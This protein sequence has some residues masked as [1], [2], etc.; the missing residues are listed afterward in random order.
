MYDYAIKN[1]MIVDGTGAE[2]YRAAVYLQ[3]D[4]IAKIT[5]EDLPAKETVDAAGLAVA[6]GFMD[7]HTHS[8]TTP[9]CAPG[10]ETALTQGLTFH[11]GGNC[12]GSLVPNM[13]EEHLNVGVSSAKSRFKKPMETYDAYDFAS[14][15]DEVE[16]NGVAVNFSTLIG[17]GRLRR[18]VMADPK[19]T[20]PTAEELKGMEEL[21]EKQLKQGA[22]GM[23]IGL[24]YVPGT[25]A[26]TEELIALSKVVAKY[27][28]IVAVHMRSESTEVM[29]A[30]DEMCRVAK[31]SGAHVH[32]SHF[33]LMYE[34]QWGR[35]EELLR[36]LDETRAAGANIT[37]DQYP[38]EAS[39]T[40][41][42]SLLPMNMKANHA[43][44][45]EY[46]MDDAKYAQVRDDMEKKINSRG[47]GARIG[48]SRTD[49]VMP[50]AD[51]KTLAEI[52]D[53]LG[54]P[55]VDAF[56]EIMR[57]S[58]CK[59]GL[60]YYAINEQDMLTIAKRQDIAVAS[61][62]YGYD[63]LVE[64][65]IGKPHPRSAGAFTRFLRLAREHQL[66]PLEKAVRKMTGLPASLLGIKDRGVLKEGNFADV[67]IF[68]PETIT[69]N[70][71][72]A[73]PT[74]PATG[75]K[76]VFVNGVKAFVDGKP[77]GSRSGRF[78][79]LQ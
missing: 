79:T 14:Y 58:E 66:M 63:N 57:R 8:D 2:P 61:D 55:V 23:S 74:K 44:A 7:M 20:L 24:T 68:D 9:Y 31:E 12:G 27:N 47:G 70:A 54:M 65:P 41:A 3:G 40:G 25:F 72:F 22:P 35:A 5:A 52:A 34:A 28:G 18:C 67:V 1:G 36:K 4:K 53:M 71:T 38:Y 33:K 69:D 30:V 46:L 10:F 16:K 39:S 75:V 19:A 77:T 21:L 15:C 51:G 73:E 42:V 49:G 64:G 56:R 13:P 26:E 17:H 50:E 37:A 76:C 60:I 45:M 29:E 78:L 6:P 48:I 32:I 59:S 11:L 62:G 43:M